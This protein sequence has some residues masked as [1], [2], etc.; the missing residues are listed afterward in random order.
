MLCSMM[1]SA[2]Y[3]YLGSLPALFVNSGHVRLQIAHVTHQRMTSDGNEAAKPLHLLTSLAFGWLGKPSSLLP[4]AIA[5]A[6]AP[7]A[8]AAQGGKKNLGPNLGWPGLPSCVS[9]H[10]QQANRYLWMQIDKWLSS[11]AGL[12]R[13]FCIDHSSRL[14]ST[15]T[16]YRQTIVS[17]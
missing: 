8:L 2:L 4:N 5:R 3:W 6:R 10:N 17:I 9:L 14:R 11:H 15:I 12:A 13:F 16:F 1:I 7:R